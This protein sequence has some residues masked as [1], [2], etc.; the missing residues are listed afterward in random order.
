[1]Q[2]IFS[3][4]ELEDFLCTDKNLEK[5]L[6]LKF[7]AR[8]VQISPAGI[9]D[10]LAYH[11]PSNHFIIIELKK[12]LLDVNALI[13][14]I[15]YLRYYQELR[16]FNYVHRRKSR[17]FSL[18]LIGQNIDV[19]LIKT[20]NRYCKDETFENNKIYHSL[21]GIDFDKGISFE[22]HNSSHTDYQ[23]R[24]EDIRDNFETHAYNKFNTRF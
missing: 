13:Q 7:I 18:L 15:S 19:G 1:M 4:R 2:I 9:V 23:D 5:Y 3:E 22:F 12:D 16:S 6:G 24:I 14:G 11:K 8:Q 21:F 17:N 10:I 20:T